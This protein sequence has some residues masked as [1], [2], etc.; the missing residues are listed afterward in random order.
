MRTQTS[1]TSKK[2]TT[3][4][5]FSERQKDS[6]VLMFL[7][8]FLPEE[9]ADEFHHTDAGVI[10]TILEDRGYKSERYRVTEAVVGK[11]QMRYEKQTKTLAQIA[12]EF[13][14]SPGTVRFHLARRG[15]KIKHP[16]FYR[17]HRGKKK[18]VH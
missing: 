18:K 7:S 13:E 1:R 4:G 8:G 14:T 2:K 15:V 6:I 16:A 10:K 11:W 3:L 5:I 17:H 9:I 12:E